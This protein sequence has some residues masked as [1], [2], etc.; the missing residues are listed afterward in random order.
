MGS[1][2]A[3]QRVRAIRWLGKFAR[4][5]LVLSWSYA[6]ISIFWIQLHK[7]LGDDDL[8]K[9]PKLPSK[10][11]IRS[12]DESYILQ[13][14]VDLQ[15]YISQVLQ[16]SAVKFRFDDSD[17]KKTIASFQACESEVLSSFLTGSLAKLSSMF[18]DIHSEAAHLKI[19]LSV[20]VVCCVSPTYVGTCVSQR[21]LASLSVERE[22]L[23]DAAAHSE[24]QRQAAVS[25][26]QVRWKVRVISTKIS[27]IDR[28][29]E[30]PSRQLVSSGSNWSAAAGAP[31]VIDVIGTA[32]F[33]AKRSCESCE[34]CPFSASF[35]TIGR[36]SHASQCRA[37]ASERKEWVVAASA[38]SGKFRKSCRCWTGRFCSPLFMRFIGW[39]SGHRSNGS[40]GRKRCWSKKWRLSELSYLRLLLTPLIMK[41]CKNRHNLNN[42]FNLK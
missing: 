38:W 16:S 10:G 5:G 11:L 25:Q 13:K 2:S 18:A 4:G 1:V 41:I 42:E 12:F 21:E 35:T 40:L 30:L 26:L 23:R 39:L 32:P 29:S 22:Q 15:V 37:A 7:E 9:F 27:R 31:V 36:F 6:C 20:C 8:K 24:S 17:S 33:V 34:S 19:M 3:L 14:Q 28:R